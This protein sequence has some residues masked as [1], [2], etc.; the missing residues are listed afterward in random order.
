M[1]PALSPVACRICGNFDGNT[2]WLVRE[3]LHGTREPFD[4]FQCRACGCLQITKI[5]DDLGRF[6]P[7]NYYSFRHFDRLA[8]SRWRRFIDRRRV[9]AGLGE[10]DLLGWAANAIGRPLDYMEWIRHAGLDTTARILDVGCGGG[11]LLL[12]MQLGG[13]G[14]CTGIDAFIDE[15]RHYQGG[16]TIHKA[17]L[18]TLAAEGGIFDFIMF[19]HSLEHMPDPLATLQTAAGMLSPRGFILVVVPVADSYAWETYREHWYNLDAPR[20]LHLFTREAMRLLASEAGLYVED[21][22]STG[23]V[24]QLSESERYKRGIT[25]PSKTKAVH[26]LGRRRMRELRRMTALLNR[27]GRSD[28]RIFYFRKSIT[29]PKVETENPL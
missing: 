17:S 4:Y 23:G 25:G 26:I 2:T 8:S 29:A 11:K 18:E 14:Q 22:V 7:E 21:A 10:I 1:N 19:H 12:R 5:P 6:Y 15:T 3:M 24:S 16:L 20:H 28:Q 9:N 27:E 13:F